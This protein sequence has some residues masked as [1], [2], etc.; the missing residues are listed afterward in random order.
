M[1][2]REARFKK[3]LTQYDVNRDSGVHQSRISL[4]ERGY[5]SPTL[6]EKRA[7]SK[8]LQ[9]NSKEIDWPAHN[10]GLTGGSS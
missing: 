8:V 9:I 3:G 1:D 10:K 4:I 7:I 2:L 5:V 6:K